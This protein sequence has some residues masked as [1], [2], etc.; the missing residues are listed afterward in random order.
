[1]H[2]DPRVIVVGSGAAGMMAAIAASERVSCLLISNGPIG[3]SNSVMAQGGLQLPLPT[4]ES[5]ELFYA[6]ARS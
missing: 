3:R 2:T 4:A 6:E 5:R 1:M